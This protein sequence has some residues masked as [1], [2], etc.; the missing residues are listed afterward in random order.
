MDTRHPGLSRFNYFFDQL[1]PLLNKSSK[2]KNP[3]LWLYINKVRTP[4]F[5][6]EGLSK[7]YSSFHNKN[8]F[9][10]LKEHFKSLEDALGAID[11]YDAFA[12]EFSQ[13]NNIPASVTEYIQ[14]QTREKIQSLNE[15]LGENK[16][17]S[18]SNERI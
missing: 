2:Q 13:N 6:L 9:I 5:M 14:A 18:E 10:K 17:I 3:A 11:Y 12:K 7:I 4:L 16:W 8:K 1:Q 15:I